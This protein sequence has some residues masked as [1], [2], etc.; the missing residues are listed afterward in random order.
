M[1]LSKPRR[2]EKLW[3]LLVT[4]L[5][6]ALFAAGCSDPEKA[7][8]EHVSKGEAHLKERKFEEATIEFRNAIQIDDQLVAAHW[9]M[10]RA[11]EGLERFPEALEELGR[12][13]QLDANHSESR[14]RMGNYMMLFKPARIDDAERLANEVLEK[15]PNNPEGHILMATVLFARD[16]EKNRQEALSRLNRAIESDPKRIESH[17]SLARFYEQIGDTA[18]TEETIRRAIATDDKSSLGYVS[19]AGFMARQRR[20]DEAEAAL[21]KAV[22][23]APNDRTSH[24]MLA[25]FYH[26]NTKQLD[27]AEAAYKA[28]A[29]IDSDNPESRVV[30]GDFYSTVGRFDEAANV[31]REILAKSPD[32]NKGRYRLSE[33]LLQ[34]G[35]KDGASKMVD[36]IL[37]KNDRDLEARLMRARINVQNGEHKKAIEDLKEVLSMDARNRNGL[38]FMAEANL[39]SGQVDQARTYAGDLERYYPEW[40]P[41]KMLQVQMALVAGDAQAA[42]RQATEL[43]GNLSKPTQVSQLTPQLLSEMQLKAL[44]ARGS[45]NLQLKKIDEARTDF[46]AARNMAPNAPA[47]YNNLAAVALNDKKVDEAVENY[48]RALQL[49]TANLD[50]L[51]ALTNVYFAQRR[52]EQAHARIDQAL[53][54]QPRNPALHLLKAQ[55]FGMREPGMMKSEAELQE[56][57]RNVEA[58]LR[59]AIEM[60]D[61]YLPAYRA[62]ASLYINTNQPD[63][64]LAE[65]RKVSERE[66]GDAMSHTMMGMVEYGRNNHDAAVENYKR[67]LEVDPEQP[68]AANNLAM[69][70]ADQ[71]KGNLDEAVRLA[72]SIVQK[73]PDQPGYID[74]LGWVYHKKGLHLAAVEQLQRAV[75]KSVERKADNSL[76]RFHLGMALAGAGQKA[77]A[78]RELQ[79]ALRLAEEESKRPGA[80]PFAQAEEARQALATL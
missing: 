60:D 42:Q 18:K 79:T 31:Y 67:A 53:A 59:R 13:I 44:S 71:G 17:L 16:P 8:A 34:K 1:N 15:D 70:Y 12:V 77:E 32:F 36:E 10:V 55:A 29:A 22:E 20:N 38:Y 64:A 66:P 27:K 43:L 62:L 28:A 25:S 46:E 33:V 3:A 51:N 65:F 2:P 58:S 19:L 40:A 9:G 35:D 69:L 52:L 41:A 54:A 63:R 30:L 4:V 39:R 49:D 5:A 48:E 72:Q 21:K 57:T 7:K 76:Y 37:Q 74:T 78:K 45:A 23:T 80:R 24:L 11:Y 68:F 26:I 73:F 14:I 61:R 6:A 56:S 47:V 75:D 50:A